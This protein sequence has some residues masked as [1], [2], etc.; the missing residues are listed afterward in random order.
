[1]IP[2]KRRHQHQTPVKLLVTRSIKLNNDRSVS[3]LTRILLNPR[4]LMNDVRN[5]L[6]QSDAPFLSTTVAPTQPVELFR[7]DTQDRQRIFFVTT[8]EAII[9][10]NFRQLSFLS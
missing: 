1:M 5:E 8:K 7:L 6:A 10:A 4:L 9:D 2:F 3:D